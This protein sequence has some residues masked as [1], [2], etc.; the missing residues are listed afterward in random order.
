MGPGEAVHA[1][2]T[3]EI[4]AFT[5]TLARGMARS[6][7]RFYVLC[8]EADRDADYSTGASTRRSSS[9]SRAARAA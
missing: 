9:S 3:G 6:N 1:A 4:V 2:Y 5:R 8:P 7:A